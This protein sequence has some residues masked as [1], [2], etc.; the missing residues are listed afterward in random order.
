MS[1]PNLLFI[2]YDQQRYD[3]VGAAGVYPVK[4]PNLDAL[5]ARGAWFERAYTPIPVCAPA[6]Q[7][8]FTGR[9]PEESG[10]LWNPHIVFPLNSRPE[11]F[12]WTCAICDAGYN[13][14]LVGLWELGGCAPA[15]YGFDRHISRADLTREREEHAPGIQFTNGFFG[16]GD[17]APLEHNNTHI[18]ARRAIG[19]LRRLHKEGKDRK[20]VV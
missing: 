12:R 13:T 11:G 5:A 6:R 19:E 15:D 1:K 10:G 17:P 8:L 9:R 16:E 2:M 3:C 4:T 7:A 18:T 14:S 20:S